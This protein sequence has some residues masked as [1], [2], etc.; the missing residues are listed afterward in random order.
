MSEMEFIDLFGNN[1]AGRHLNNAEHYDREHQ[2][3]DDLDFDTISTAPSPSERRRLNDYKHTSHRI[4]KANGN[5]ALNQGRDFADSGVIS[6]SNGNG[7]KKRE[8]K[9]LNISDEKIVWAGALF[10]FFGIFVFLIGFWLGKTTIGSI[11]PQEDSYIAQLQEKLD[12]KKIETRLASG[13]EIR[14]ELPVTKTPVIQPEKSIEDKDVAPIVAP[15]I[16]QPSPQPVAP[17]SETPRTS[18]PSPSATPK[19]ETT[20]TP[21]TSTPASVAR[22]SSDVK[23]DFTIQVSAHTQM[24]RARAIEDSL[25]SAGFQAYIVE[26]TVNGRRFFRV[27]VGRF[28]SRN[29]AQKALEKIKAT[30]YGKDAILITL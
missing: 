29:E 30:T 15:P 11:K 25:R 1:S 9:A 4:S 8:Q 23:G 19:P 18:A 3:S 27:R 10:V 6:E 7:G 17:K 21:A 12:E 16:K 2:Y 20:A 26:T 14:S 22:P 28:D 24:E 13:D 5:G